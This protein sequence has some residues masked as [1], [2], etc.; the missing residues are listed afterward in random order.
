MVYLAF[1]KGKGNF[2]NKLVRFFTRSRYSH[3]VIVVQNTKVNLSVDDAFE[4][5]DVTSVQYSSTSSKGG[6]YALRS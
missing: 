1:Y 2:I 6:V 4:Y 5:V 3:C